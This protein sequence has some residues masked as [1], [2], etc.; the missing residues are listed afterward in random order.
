MNLLIQYSINTFCHHFTE[1]EASNHNKV[2]SK[3]SSRIFT[4]ILGFVCLS[5]IIEFYCVS[6]LKIGF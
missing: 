6:K 3:L 5:F 1:I 2:I 4:N